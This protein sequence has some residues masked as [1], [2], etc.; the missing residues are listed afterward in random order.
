MGR[1]RRSDEATAREAQAELRDHVRAALSEQG[2]RHRD[3]ADVLGLAQ[4]P[5]SQRMIGNQWFSESEV[6]ATAAYLSKS[7]DDLMAGSYYRKDAHQAWLNAEAERTAKERAKRQSPRAL[8]CECATLRIIP[9]AEYRDL[10]GGSLRSMKGRYVGSFYCEHCGTETKH[11]VLRDLSANPDELESM[12]A[13]PTAEQVAA[14]ERDQLINR[15][16]GFNVDVRYRRL[17]TRKYRIEHGVPIVGFE[18]DDSKSQ[19]RIEVNPDAP[20]SI[21]VTKIKR[22][23][24]VISTDEDGYWNDGDLGSAEEGAW[25]LANDRAWESVASHLETEIV[26]ATATEK[27]KLVVEIQDNIASDRRTDS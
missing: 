27:L 11:A 6:A 21:Q 17:G 23:W 7:L 2:L 8:C 1:Q 18:Y 12:L 15:L 22:A 26:R 24:E 5:M 10:D 19:W 20:P 3:L 9:V 25:L 14:K 4:A 13:E 16:V